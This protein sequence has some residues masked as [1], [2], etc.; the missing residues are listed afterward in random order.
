MI[1]RELE[2]VLTPQEAAERPPREAWDELIEAAFSAPV[3]AYGPRELAGV[4]P[5]RPWRAQ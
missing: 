3:P 4:V 2:P 5:P 1:I